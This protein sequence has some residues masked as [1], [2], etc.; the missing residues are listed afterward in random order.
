MEAPNIFHGSSNNPKCIPCK[1]P[2]TVPPWKQSY[3]HLLSSTCIYP[4][5]NPTRTWSHPGLSLLGTFLP[6]TGCIHYFFPAQEPSEAYRPSWSHPDTCS[7]SFHA[8]YEPWKTPFT[9][10]GASTDFHVKEKWLPSLLP[11]DINISST[12]VIHSRGSKF[13]IILLLN[14]YFHGRISM[15]TKTATN[16]HTFMETP[17]LVLTEIRNKNGRQYHRK[18]MD[19]IHGSS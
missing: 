2:S 12:E 14:V 10:M 16:F 4:E 15:E 7:G 13:S 6:P 9:S 19:E 3:F 17:I 11:L 5:H 8:H 1:L 18:S